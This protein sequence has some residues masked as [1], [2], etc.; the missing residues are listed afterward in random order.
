MRIIQLRIEN[1]K[2][3]EVANLDLE[4]GL[5]AIAG[6]NGAGKSSALDAICAAIGGKRLCPNVPIRTGKTRAEVQ[7]DL[8]EIR[9]TRT[10]KADGSSSVHVTSA[11]GTAVKRPQEL[12][13]SLYDPIAFDLSGLLALPPIKQRQYLLDALG[14]SAEDAQLEQR[15]RS[16]LDIVNDTR[17]EAQRLQGELDLIEPWPNDTPDASVDLVSAAIDRLQAGTLAKQHAR[18]ERDRTQSEVA[19]LSEHLKASIARRSELEKQ[20]RAIE[21]TIESQTAE[22]ETASQC[23]A[24]AAQ[25]YDQ[26]PEPDASEVSELRVREQHVNAAVGR[27]ARAAECRRKL[28][29]IS[30]AHES[31]KATLETIVARRTEMLRGAFGRLPQL[32][33]DETGLTYNGLP[34][35]QASQSERIRV[36]FALLSASIAAGERKL[37]LVLIRDGSLLDD[38]SR[39]ALAQEADKLGMQALVEIVGAGHAGD[40]VIE[41]GI[42]LGA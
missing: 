21:K 37:K 12:L 5:T 32:G 35:T 24:S 38:D 9:V 33:Y 16:A 7:V 41:D 19:T 28:L 4:D 2:R 6:A 14:L 20:L 42:V 40:I 27:K 39:A 26:T 3:I 18:V 10:W 23:A 13:D 17:R 36:A 31:A 15:K 8:G 1:F 22:L 29:E 11:P 34:L 25:A 30:S